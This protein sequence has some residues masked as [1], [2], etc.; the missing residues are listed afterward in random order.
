MQHWLTREEERASV[1]I[2][3]SAL[4]L[5]PKPTVRRSMSYKDPALTSQAPGLMRKVGLPD[6]CMKDRI[7]LIARVVEVTISS[8]PC[9][10]IEV[11]SRLPNAAYGVDGRGAG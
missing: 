6:F 4:P 1:Y 3:P 5:N 9:R 10:L 11:D 2:M 8:L 7:P